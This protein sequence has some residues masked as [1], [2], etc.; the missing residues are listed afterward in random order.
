MRISSKTRSQKSYLTQIGECFL[1]DFSPTFT[2]DYSALRQQFP[3][4]IEC[5][6]F[7]S[8]SS[9]SHYLAQL[10]ASNHP[11]ICIARAQTH[12]KG[13]HGRTWIAPKNSSVLLSVRYPFALGVALNGLSLVIGLAVVRVL[14]RRYQLSNVALKWPND[15]YLKHQKLA[16]ILLENQIQNTRQ[17]VIIGLGLNVNLG[18]DFACDTAWTDLAHHLSKLPDLPTLSAELIAQIFNYCELF[19]RH[20]LAYFQTEWRRYDYLRAKTLRYQ[21]KRRTFVGTAVGINSLGALLIQTRTQNKIKVEPVFS[22]KPLSQ[23][24]FEQLD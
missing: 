16:G 8:I 14:I 9:T 10:P 12:G 7:D 13:Q 19:E 17:T 24:G 23:I 22:S 2:M 5:W 15:V 11:Q 6:V 18:A 21:G 4:P 1:T 3:A 20:G